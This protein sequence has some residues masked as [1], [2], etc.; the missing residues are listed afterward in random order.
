MKSISLYPHQKKIVD[1]VK[2]HPHQ[3]TYHFVAPPG[4]GKTMVGLSLITESKK[5]TLILVPSLLLKEQWEMQAITHFPL[6]VSLDIFS[7]AM[8]TITTYQAMYQQVQVNPDCLKE[9]EWILLD[10][11]HHLK[12]AWGDV[13]IEAREQA[14]ELVS[15]SL[16]ATPPLTSN[17]EEWRTYI[18]LNGVI[19]EEITSPELVKQHLLNPYQDFVYFIKADAQVEQNY[20]QFIA[21]QNDIVDQLLADTEV[22][23]LLAAHPFIVTPLAKTHQIYQQFDLYIAMLIFLSNNQFELSKDHWEVLGFKKKSILPELSKAHLSLVYEWLWETAP[24]LEIFQRLKTAHW[25]KED[26]L[27]LFP[28]F[29]KEKLAGSHEAKMEAINHIVIQEEAALKQKLSCV[30]LFDRIYEE[31]FDFQSNPSY[32]GVI[33]Q[34]LRLHE[35]VAEETELAVICGKF[36]LVSSQIANLYFNEEVLQ[37]MKG[38]E[39]FLRINLT[40]KNRKIMLSKGTNLLEEHQLQIVIGPVALLGE[41]WN[42]RSVATVILGNNS[43]SYVQIQQLRGRALRAK[44]KKPLSAI[45]HIGQYLPN[46]SWQEQ[47]ELAP[48]LNRLSYIEGISNQQVPETITTGI[49]RLN[50]PLETSVQALET[51]NQ[52]NF[53]FTNNREHLIAFWQQGLAKGTH[54]TMPVFIRKSQTTASDLQQNEQVLPIITRQTFWASLIHGRFSTYFHQQRTQK[55]W[56]KSCQVREKLAKSVLKV[57]QASGTI[58]QQV[59]VQMT[60][61]N[62]EFRIQLIDATYQEE[63]LFNSALLEVMRPVLDTRYLIRIKKRYFSV[64]RKWARTKQ[65]ATLFFNEV[66]KEF[67]TSELVYTRNTLGRQKLIQAHIDSLKEQ[68]LEVIEERLWQ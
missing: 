9:F 49:E 28:T 41:G 67:S 18:Q 32:Y 19:D 17:Q 68:G 53:F 45:W 3:K 4:S 52:Q 66:K 58:R 42:C 63:R 2:T 24:Q 34:F 47:P 36:L 35:L 10:E 50:F 1:Y 20:A 5:K 57:F 48:I 56:K 39:N 27:S 16:T 12:K 55:L 30:I 13:L 25:L 37:E 7:P 54:M 21:R 46:L 26:V 61:D 60:V 38:I 64:P 11:A 31:A 6:S 43:S 40:E 8:I 65:L 33:P 44:E 22:V 15:I 23:H 14:E 59:N 62:H 51:Y 29:P